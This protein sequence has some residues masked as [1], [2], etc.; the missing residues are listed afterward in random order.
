[1]SK[2]TRQ[3]LARVEEEL[4]EF[5]LLGRIKYA[6]EWSDTVGQLRYGVNFSSAAPSKRS[7]WELLS[8]Y[9]D[10]TV[11]LAEL[12]LGMKLRNQL[13]GL[14][15]EDRDA[16]LRTWA[17]QPGGLNE[18]QLHR[19]T[20]HD[21]SVEE[22]ERE[23]DE[24]RSEIAPKISAIRDGLIAWGISPTDALWP[25]ASTDR[26]NP[27]GVV[28]TGLAKSR[29]S[30]RRSAYQR[31]IRAL[32]ETILAKQRKVIYQD[33]AMRIT[34]QHADSLPTELQKRMVKTRFTG[35]LLEFFEREEE[36]GTED[37]DE[38]GQESKRFKFRRRFI[39]SFS[40]VKR[41]YEKAQ[42]S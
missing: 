6:N 1:M 5:Q 17:S 22:L 34:E 9:F 19:L 25:L 24:T 12:V 27:R 8:W 7:S 29:K 16:K 39:R 11:D 35:T 10:R 38:K 41:A 28:N 33:V 32:I 13:E 2:P 31:L 40:Q 20:R 15:D 30:R 26:V 18:Y 42:V 23:I 37:A 4:D 14:S 3:E 36:I 21:R